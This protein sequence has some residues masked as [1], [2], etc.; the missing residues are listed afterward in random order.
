MARIRP[1]T[2]D[3]IGRDAELARLHAWLEQRREGTRQIVFVTG[4]PGIG[5]TTLVDAFLASAADGGDV[6]DGARPMRRALRIGRSVPAGARSTRTALPAADGAAAIALLGRYAP[7]W[8]AQMPGLV[9][10]AELEAVQR[11]AQGATRE[12]ML[13]ELA[14]ALE[15]LTAPTR[16]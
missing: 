12:R 15:A 7:T 5:K 9:G 16:R 6:C 3:L 14:E 4:E 1:E 8:L 10:D 11:R 13:R 2:R